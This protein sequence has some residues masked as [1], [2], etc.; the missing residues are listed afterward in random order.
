MKH[1]VSIKELKDFSSRTQLV[2]LSSKKENKSIDMIVYP[3]QQ[4]I[5]FKVIDQKGSANDFSNLKDAINFY[6]KL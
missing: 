4:R 6:N 3:V 5:F 1:K 2:S